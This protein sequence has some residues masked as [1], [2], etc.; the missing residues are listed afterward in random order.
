MLA[1]HATLG[2]QFKGIGTFSGYNEV[3]VESASWIASL[4]QSVEAFFAVAGGSG[5]DEA[6]V[7]QAHQAFARQYGAG[8]A[9]LVRLRP[10][11][12]AQPFEDMT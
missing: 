7:R 3:I 12:W 4:P 11:R 9:P 10:D 6:F 5:Q 8:A 1:K 2:D